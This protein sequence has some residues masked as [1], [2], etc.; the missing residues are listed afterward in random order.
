VNF[1]YLIDV[2]SRH[3]AWVIAWALKHGATEIE[4][5]VDAEAAWID[6]VL[7]RSSLIAGR[8]KSCTP[9]YYN[10][11]GQ[12]DATLSQNSFFFGNPTEYA[13]ILETCRARNSLDG[14]EIRGRSSS[15]SHRV[16]GRRR[17]RRRGAV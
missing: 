11:E 9:G 14:L 10:R 15:V 12:A 7:Q 16:S 5:M 17:V 13:D 6:T 8:R 3:V 1:P 4:A 2:Q